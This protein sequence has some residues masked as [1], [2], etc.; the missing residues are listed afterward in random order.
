MDLGSI[1]A[2]QAIGDERI[3]AELFQIL[4][5]NAIKVLH[6]MC[7]QIWKTQQWS[8]YW[9]KSV[10]I[11][12]PKKGNAKECSNYHTNYHI[13]SHARNVMLKILQDRPQQY[14]NWECLDV[15][16]V[17]RIDRETRDQIANIQSAESW[18]KQGNSRKTYS[19]ALLI[20]IKLLTFLVDHNKLWKILKELR[21]SDH[22][23][24]LLKTCMQ[25]KKQQN[26]TWNKGLV[27]NW[28][29]STS[30]LH[31]DTLLI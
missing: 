8:Q 16:A 9:R 29:R 30:R 10:F 23:I 13:I 11:L 20:M 6:S 1:T 15:Q 25:V 3:L 22:L 17:F 26:Q 5:D 24:C 14:M 4:K 27:Q 19:S 7:P 18:E 21:M 28:E 31:P 12:I 2:K